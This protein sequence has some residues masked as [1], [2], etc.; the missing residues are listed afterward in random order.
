M[1]AAWT[2]LA[3]NTGLIAGAIA[4]IRALKSPSSALIPRRLSR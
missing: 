3:I 1:V 4:A 2:E